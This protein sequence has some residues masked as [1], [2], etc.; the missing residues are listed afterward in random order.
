[1]EMETEM[2]CSH[3]CL[4]VSFFF[5]FQQPVW[6]CLV[7]RASVGNFLIVN[8]GG[9]ER[10]MTGAFDDKNDI[11]SFSLKQCLNMSVKLS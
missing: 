4:G 6:E 10:C 2:H 3:S 1:M 7:P 5:I 8:V 9:K 11:Q